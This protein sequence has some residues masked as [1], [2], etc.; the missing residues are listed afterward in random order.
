MKKV[1]SILLVVIILMIVLNSCFGEDQTTT[2]TLPTNT[3]PVITKPTHPTTTTT[4]INQE[5]PVDP[6]VDNEYSEGLEYTLNDDGKSYSVT[7][8]GICTDT[9]IV[10][11]S[12]YE[13]SPVTSIGTSAFAYGNSITSVKIPYSV[14]SIDS[15]FILSQALKS[16]E[17]DVN[18]QHYVSIDGNLYSK[19]L[20]TLIQYAIAKEATSFTIPDFVIS[21]GVGAFYG[22]TSLTKIIIPDSVT[23]IGMGAL[24]WCKSL[25]SIEV[26]VN[27]QCYQSIAGNL[28][29]K[30]GKTLVQYAIGKEDTL[31]TIPNFVTNIYFGAF[32][33]C[34][35]L[36]S[37]VIPNSVTSIGANVFP[38]CLS[39]TSINYD[40]SVDQWGAINK[41]DYWDYN[42]QTYTIYC[43]NGEISKD[44]TVTYK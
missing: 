6:P 23:S 41:G 38:Y 34:Y 21:I 13:G 17:V 3:S 5:S 7:G 27:N 32:S 10:I 1:F 33:L 29:T 30:D 16:I 37:I 8:I 28:Y 43:T 36:T 12:I 25:T 18:N 40:G 22:C 15:S 35:S 39:L 31:F 19:D 14:T 44:G 20:K 24:M 2:V 26:D 4:T 42:T 9:D 11:P